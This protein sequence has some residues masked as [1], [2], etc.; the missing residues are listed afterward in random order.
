MLSSWE[1]RDHQ[2]VPGAT[3]STLLSPLPPSNGRPHNSELYSVLGLSETKISAVDFYRKQLFLNQEVI[4]K[5][6]KQKQVSSVSLG[7]ER[8]TLLQVLPILSRI[9][10]VSLL[11]QTYSAAREKLSAKHVTALATCPSEGSDSMLHCVC[12]LLLG[13]CCQA[14]T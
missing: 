10:L 12:P 9:T 3:L 2:K 7:F 11:P 13:N 1:A 4:L 8:P 5:D 14:S 6:R